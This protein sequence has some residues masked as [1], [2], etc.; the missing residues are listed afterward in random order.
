MPCWPVRKVFNVP[1]EVSNKERL[2]LSVSNRLW[3]ELQP[4][5]IGLNSPAK[6]TLK[7]GLMPASYVTRTHALDKRGISA[8]T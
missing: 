4:S 2:G 1:R 7:C 5:H 3:I 6:A 8:N